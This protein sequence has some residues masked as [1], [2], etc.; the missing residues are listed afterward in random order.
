MV[1]HPASVAVNGRVEKFCHEISALGVFQVEQGVGA[2]GNAAR[3]VN[4]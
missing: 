1:N 3:W 4:I 2:P